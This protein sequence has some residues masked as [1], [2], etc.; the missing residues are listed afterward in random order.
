MPKRKVEARDAKAIS[1]RLG[2]F[3]RR[4]NQRQDESLGE[5]RIRL[6]IPRTTW[7]K[8]VDK[9]PS[10]PEARYLLRLARETNLN[11]NWLLL[12][13]GPCL[14][15]REGKSGKEQLLAAVEAELRVSEGAT[16]EEADRLW[17]QVVA[18]YDGA[19]SEAAEK[20]IIGPA[21]EAIRPFYRRALWLGRG[22]IWAGAIP[23]Q[24]VP[25]L[26]GWEKGREGKSKSVVLTE[27]KQ[28]T[29]S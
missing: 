4:Q 20:A 22:V 25:V 12:G 9:D 29:M 27:V 15:E 17:K 16:A 2:D 11:L 21:V 23:G 6:D 1:Q 28:D 8:W 19:D 24:T 14:R 26:F 18:R 10:V 3:I 7:D 5:F 13:E